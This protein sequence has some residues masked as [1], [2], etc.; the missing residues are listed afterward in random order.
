MKVKSLSHVWLLA[1]PW[2][3]ACQAPPSM[4]FS[5]QKST[6]VGCHCLLWTYKWPQGGAIKIL[7]FGSILSHGDA[8]CQNSHFFLSMP[9]SFS[10][11][12]QIITAFPT[13]PSSPCSPWSMYPSPEKFKWSI[14]GSCLLGLYLPHWEAG[15][16]KFRKVAVF[17]DTLPPS[18]YP[19]DGLLEG[20]VRPTGWSPLLYR[21]SLDY[22]P[23]YETQH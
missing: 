3:K 9:L 6:G 23:H 10:V 8:V 7:G 1:T 16:V 11:Y 22:V 17:S 13:L 20:M 19:T 15:C 5:R 2:T 4:G 18:G 21:R 12:P 14:W